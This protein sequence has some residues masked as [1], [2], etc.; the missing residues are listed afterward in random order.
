M[1]MNDLHACAPWM[2]PQMSEED[3]RF[4]GTGVTGG[5]KPPCGCWASNL[6]PVEEQLMF[7]TR[8]SFL[9]TSTV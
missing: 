7:L 8:E 1:C 4:L 9:Q 5:C 2:Y 3:D 6:G